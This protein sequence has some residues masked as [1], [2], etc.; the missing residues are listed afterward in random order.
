MVL[1]AAA[2]EGSEYLV[3]CIG[4]YS[5][6]EFSLVFLVLQRA[7]RRLCFL[8]SLDLLLAAADHNH[9]LRADNLLLLLGQL[10][11]FIVYKDGHSVR[12]YGIRDLGS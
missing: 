4:S 6:V 1:V 10:G 7:G 9:D 11:A 2:E 3:C 5:S 12:W 8:T